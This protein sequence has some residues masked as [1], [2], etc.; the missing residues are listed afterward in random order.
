MTSE[1]IPLLFSLVVG[2][3][4]GLFFYGG[5]WWTVSKLASPE[6]RGGNVAF[7]FLGSQVVRTVGVVSGFYLVS[8]G[9]WRKL[10]ISF[11]GF[12]IGRVVV[13]RLTRPK[14]GVSRAA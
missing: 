4:L 9:D 12:I 14:V 8:S 11:L 10:L 13:S 7:W 6:G 3:A 1:F 2:G 5:L